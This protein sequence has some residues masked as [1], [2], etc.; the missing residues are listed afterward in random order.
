MLLSAATLGN[1]LLVAGLAL[2]IAAFLCA[3][4]SSLRWS[5]QDARARGKSGLH[6]VLWVALVKWPVG[7][8][9]WLLFRPNLPQHAAGGS[10][11][12]ARPPRN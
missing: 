1:A 3:Y 7:L 11:Q 4:V 2:L 5:Y 12:S 10:P 9:M 8:L 6:V